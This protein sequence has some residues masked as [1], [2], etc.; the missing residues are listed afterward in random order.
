MWQS[1]A[2][3]IIRQRFLI[4]VFLG[5]ITLTCGYYATKVT[6]AYD[7]AKVIP[8]D[9][10]DYIDYVN[11]KNRFGE[12]GSVLVVGVRNNDIFKKEFFNSFY[13]LCN[14]IEKTDGVE[15][16]VSIT[17]IY[18]INKNEEKHKFELNPLFQNKVST[19]AELDSLHEIISRL[20]F[21]EG[22]LLNDSGNTTLAAITLKKDKLDSKERITLVENIEKAAKAFG[23]QHH[24]E[25]YFSGLPYIRTV[26]ATKV[27]NELQLFTL[28]SLIVTTIIMWLFF[29]SFVA[30]FYSLIVVIIG[31]VV[32]VGSIAILGYKI[33]VL[34]GLVPPL[35]V[36]IGIQNCI[37]L[38]NVYHQEYRQHKN[39]V[40]SLTRV[41]SKNGLALFLTNVTTAI[42]FGVFNFTGSSLLDE[43]SVVSA[44]DIMVVYIVSALFIPV[45]YTF[46]PAPT[47]KQ[48]KHL[49][50]QNMSGFMQWC[51]RMVFEKRKWIY[52]ATAF[53]T[54]AGGI[55]F[56]QVK[57]IG[58][59]LDDVPKKD[60]VYTDL[61]FFE[62]QFKGVMPFEIEIDSKKKGT[63]RTSLKALS[64][65]DD[66]QNMLSSYKEFSKPVSLLEMIKFSSQ[67]FHGYSAE[68]Y[69]LPSSD[70]FIALQG[71]MQMKKGGNMSLVKSLVDSN[72]QVARISIQMADVGSV[73]TNELKKELRARIDSIFPPEKYAVKMTGTSLIFL[74]GNDY[75]IENL[76][77]SMALALLL[78]SILMA[79]LFLSWRM[80]LISL[81]PNIIPL[82]ITLGIMGFGDIHLKAST[83]IIFSI[84]YG[85]SID[86]TI[87]FLAKYRYFLKK[88][89]WAISPAVSDSILESGV[90]IVYTS[91][92]LFCG[93]IIFAFSTFGGTVALGLLTSITLF[94]GMFMNLLLLPAMLVSLEKYINMKKELSNQL[95]DFDGE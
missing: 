91:V 4:L 13:D 32:T 90:S 33:T 60:K 39:R 30:T 81:V 77:G 89:Q 36:I 5:I 35:I 15:K 66:L 87:H 34:M 75:L 70:E 62:S 24:T 68:S 63:F 73:R 54:I 28:L 37:Y 84:T 14:N 2:G 45:V 6:I 17:K 47:P 19:Q 80:I 69:Q 42:G 82:I 40:L 94:I 26:Y 52:I 9:D 72:W 67:A 1:I 49:D 83:I 16:I 7:F 23:E 22:I 76:T 50:N 38:L 79:F 93:F 27:R 3:F 18:T 43:F 95:I 74:K 71:Y 78:N 92:I 58:Y 56:T 46:L 8:K 41:T 65:M 53:L 85:I 20:K 21:Y 48:L 64:K 10:S 57:S 86:F 31:V 61:K 88:N 55:G 44:I 59:I 12:D 11:F 29:R 25:V 51:K